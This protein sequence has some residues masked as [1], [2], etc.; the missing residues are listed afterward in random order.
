MPHVLCAGEVL[1]ATFTSINSPDGSRSQKPLLSKPGGASAQRSRFGALLK[2]GKVVRVTTERQM[3]QALALALD[4]QTPRVIVAGGFQRERLPGCLHVETKISV[5]ALRRKEIRNREDKSIKRVNPKLGPIAGGRDI[6]ANGSHLRLLYE[7]KFPTNVGS[8]GPS[9][10]ALRYAVS[11]AC[12]RFS[13]TSSADA[14]LE[15]GTW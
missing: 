10:L 15:I 1:G 9:Q 12:A 2:V 5:E 11:S 8:F 6:A 14:V 4:Q 7:P 13:R 3:M